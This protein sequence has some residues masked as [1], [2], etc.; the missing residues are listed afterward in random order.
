MDTENVVVGREHVHG[1]RVSSLHGHRD[2]SIVNAREV[3]RASWLVLFW[4]EGEGVR[5]HTWHW[6]ASVVVKGLHLVEVL[7]R[8]LL[9]AILTVEDQLEGGQ[10]THGFFGVG[11]RGGTSADRNEWDTGRLGQ[12]HEAVGVDHGRHIR[13]ENNISSEVLGG[14]VPE[15]R[16]RRGVGEAPHQF[17]HWVVVGQA[18]LLGGCRGHGVVTGVL[19]LLNKVLVTL[20]REASALFGV[21]V[22]VVGVHLNT[23]GRVN[24]GVVFGRQIDVDA[25]FVVLKGDQWQV[26]TWVAVEEEEKWQVDRAFTVGSRHLGVGRLLGFIVVQV[27]VQSPPLLVVLVDALATNG[28]FNVVDRTLGDPVVIT[29]VGSL[30]RKT[31]LSSELKVHVTDKITIT[32]DSD[33][34]AT[35][36]RGGTIDSLFDVFHREVRVTLVDSLEE[37]NLWVTGQVDVLG[38]VSDELHETTGHV[39]SICTISR[40]NNFGRNRT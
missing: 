28:Q 14:E 3:A 29:S 27:I 25:H 12:W 2:L 36:S 30:G 33:G 35:R 6:G 7:T 31:L 26:Q 17:L 8:L 24:E 15:G 13:L 22:D 39:E 23:R 38:A 18:D 19:D 10:W 5:V 1:G 34:H 32:G 40:E 11:R 4:L 21:Q 37:G 16:L 9:E 20:L